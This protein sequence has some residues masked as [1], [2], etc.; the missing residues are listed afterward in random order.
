MLAESQMA[1][2]LCSHCDLSQ[3]HYT[4]HL[5]LEC[6][7]DGWCQEKIQEGLLKQKTHS[8]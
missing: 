7:F 8:F 2:E 4:A 5:G 6:F 3:C 1:A